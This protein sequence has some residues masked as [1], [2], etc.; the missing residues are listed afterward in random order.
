LKSPVSIAITP[1]LEL[2]LWF[3]GL[4]TVDFP[5]PAG[6]FAALFGLEPLFR[7]EFAGLPEDLELP[8]DVF[9]WE[10]ISRKDYSTN[11]LIAFPGSRGCKQHEV[12][13]LNIR[14]SFCSHT[15]KVFFV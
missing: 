12:K 7:E 10:V 15:I 5:T 3:A 8:R 6:L 1:T 9:F 2:P 11:G 13:L 4:F 14:F